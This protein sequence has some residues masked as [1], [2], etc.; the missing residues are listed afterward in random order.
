MEEGDNNWGSTGGLL[1]WPVGL[2]GEAPVTIPSYALLSCLPKL[3]EAEASSFSFAVWMYPSLRPL[4][5]FPCPVVLLGETERE[6]DGKRDEEEGQDAEPSA[7]AFTFSIE[8]DD[9]MGFR[10]H[11]GCEAAACFSSS[12]C[13][14]LLLSCSS[15]AFNCWTHVAI[16]G[17]GDGGLRMFLNGVE[18]A[19]FL[20]DNTT[21]KHSQPKQWNGP[22][23]LGPKC[24]EPFRGMLQDIR[25]FSCC[26]TPEKI[27]DLHK[28]R[29]RLPK[30]SAAPLQFQTCP[31]KSIEQLRDWQP[32]RDPLN[33]SHVPLRRASSQGNTRRKVI[34]CHD[35]AGGYGKDK[36]PQGG[37]SFAD[38]Y[39]FV[40]WQYLDIFIYFSHSRIAIPPPGWTNAAHK[41]GVKV[42]GTFITEWE[43]GKRECLSFLKNISTEDQEADGEDFFFA[44]QLAAIAKYYR[45]DGWFFNI[46]NELPPP[47]TQRLLRFLKYLRQLLRRELEKTEEEEV[48]LW[49]DSV[50]HDTGELKWQNVL[51]ERNAPFWRSTDGIFLNYAWKEDM[52]NQSCAFTSSACASSSAAAEGDDKKSEKEKK[53]SFSV[54]TGIDVWG[55]GTF[56]GGGF[57]CWKAL[58]VINEAS[59]SVALFAPGWTL[60]GWPLTEERVLSDRIENLFWIGDSSFL[61]NMDEENKPVERCLLHKHQAEEEHSNEPSSRLEGGWHVVEN[62]GNGWKVESEGGPSLFHKS[63]RTY[64]TSHDWCKRAKCIDLVEALLHA[65]NN[66]DEDVFAVQE[67]SE[68][69]K[70]DDEDAKRKRRKEAV[71]QYLETGP[72]ITVGQWIRG[73]GPNFGDTFC[74]QVELRNEADGVIDSWHSGEI[75]TTDGWSFVTHTFYG[76]SP[77]NELRYLYW[78]DGGK[79]TEHW[80][81]HFGS[82]TSGA[83]L[84]IEAPLL[85]C[86]SRDM[87]LSSLFLPLEGEK[88][89][90]GRTMRRVRRRRKGIGC[91][92]EEKP[93]ASSLPFYTNFCRGVGKVYCIAG[94]EARKREWSDM[95]Q[96]SIQPTYPYDNRVCGH[97]DYLHCH[98]D[99]NNVYEGGS[100]F[101]IS[102]IFLA[103]PSLSSCPSSAADV[104]YTLFELF[105]TNIPLS[106]TTTRHKK[107]TLCLAYTLSSLAHSSQLSIVLRLGHSPNNNDEPFLLSIHFPSCSSRYPPQKSTTNH[108]DN[109]IVYRHINETQPEREEDENEERWQTFYFRIPMNELLPIIEKKL[110]EEQRKKAAVSITAIDLLCFSSSNEQEEGRKHTTYNIRIGELR[111]WKEDDDEEEEDD[112]KKQRGP[113]SVQHLSAQT[114]WSTASISSSPPLCDIILSWSLPSSYSSTECYDIFQQVVSDEEEGE[115][116][117]D[118]K[119]RRAEWKGR[120]FSN[121][122][123]VQNVRFGGRTKGSNFFVRSVD[124]LGRKQP[125]EE[126]SY[127]FVERPF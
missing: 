51:N 66:E 85:H 82:R 36:F 116:G 55:R 30:D 21:H 110:E 120:S 37:S 53:D 80:A 72:P 44:H 62:G 27:R 98:H 16:V 123:Y 56:G 92:C 71:K 88:A 10:L 2:E 100:S 61:T 114:S 42:F 64:I 19:S 7:F 73:T 9:R 18:E 94:Q 43:E 65:S 89:L 109:I 3:D 70:E 6:G 68:N 57:D 69:K 121:T 28:A 86:L 58:K 1:G 79:D 99:Y 52:P 75:I 39:T 115:D 35:M 13:P 83:F 106:T 102:G 108:R 103:S 93:S 38:A 22:L 91:Y 20:L 29:P 4:R 127:V 49:Y 84:S 67:E 15:V 95:S 23:V 122:F 59:T 33:V 74:L 40:H 11:E 8:R 60:E 25:F 111:L 12:S 87:P 76:Y 97:N 63:Q 117:D 47:Y 126:A 34:H 41:H 77:S 32:G 124:Q 107:A 5:E 90:G 125:W 118:R 26:L 101:A 112:E 50:T 113:H 105:R 54:L 24:K 119:L 14:C 45:F 46:E 78:E 17:Q 104:P 96:Q 81:G 48:L 31:L